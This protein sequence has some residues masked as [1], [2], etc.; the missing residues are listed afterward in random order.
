MYSAYSSPV[1]VVPQI[2]SPGSADAV[3]TD[4]FIGDI[5][6]NHR[7]DVMSTMTSLA[8]QDLLNDLY[9]NHG[10]EG[11]QYET[12]N[13]TATAGSVDLPKMDSM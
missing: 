9:R 3:I 8:G 2:D 7:H 10:Q 5:D 4:G 11:V 1:S 12:G 6:G 13:E